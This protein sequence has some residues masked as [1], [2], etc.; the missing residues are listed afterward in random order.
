MSRILL[1]LVFAAV[2]A[3]SPGLATAARPHA[4]SE[5]SRKAHG[6]ILKFYGFYEDQAMQ[7][8]VN[9]V[10]TRVARQSDWPDAEFKFFVLDDDSINAFTT[11]CCFIYVHRGL[12]A[13]LES[14]AELATVLG[15]EIAHVTANHP[16]KR[17]TQGLLANI[18]AI[19]ATL[20]TGSGAIGQLANLGAGAWIQGYGRENEMEADRLGLKFATKAGYR[21]QAM[22]DV[23]K[24]FKDQERFELDRARREGREPRI[25]H[26]IF[27]SHPA[28]DART[29]QAAM[30]AARITSEPPGGWVDNRE[31][32]LHHLDGLPYGSSRVQGIVRDNRFYHAGMGITMAFPRAWTVDNLRDRILAYTR[33]KDTVMQVTVDARPPTQSPR[34]F[35]LTRLKGKPVAF[36]EAIE[37]NGMQGYSIVTRN[38]SPLDNGQGPVRWAVLYRD[39][40]AYVFA[41]ASRASVNSRPEAD[42]VIRSVVETMRGLKPAEFP[43]AEPYRI[44]VVPYDGKTP[45]STYAHD[46]PVESYQ[47]EELE[48]MNGLYPDKVPAFGQ[49]FKIVQ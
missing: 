12:I 43:L 22:A 10:G 9:Q 35:L 15:H 7:D 41:G 16:Q 44:A 14:E 5:S 36:S 28:P 8:Y 46:V 17:R 38:G 4:E 24:V 33:N 27:S 6:E 25:Y 37:S 23:F 40:S 19:G 13:Y 18:L 2:T 29:V 39:N 20:A 45:L 30:G 32:F 34:E 48:L 31:I 1:A 49:L 42:G 21:P 26:G 11:G 47:L 3:L